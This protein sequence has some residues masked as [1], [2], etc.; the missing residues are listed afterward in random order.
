[1]YS[2]ESVS[3]LRN[4][5]QNTLLMHYKFNLENV[6]ATKACLHACKESVVFQF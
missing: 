5:T 1:M 2:K 4:E 3:S 6:N